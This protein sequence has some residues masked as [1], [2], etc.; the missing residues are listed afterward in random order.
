MKLLHFILFIV[1]LSLAVSAQSDLKKLVETENA[2]AK[3]AAEKGTRTAFLANM[4]D[5]AVVF[6]P[7]KTLARPHWTARGESNALLSWAPNFADISSDGSL[8]YTTG[9]WEWRAKG[10]DDAPSAFGEFVTIW[11]RQT[12]GRYKFV[13]DIGISHE[14]PA[15][16]SMDWATSAAAHGTIG[17]NVSA[18]AAIAHFFRHVETKGKTAAYRSAA[19]DEIR[20]FRENR[21][22]VVGKRSA[23]VQVGTEKGV[24]SFGSGEMISTSNLAYFVKGYTLKNADG[25]LEE[26]NVVQLWKYNAGRWNLVLDILEPMPKK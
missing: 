1:I 20:L 15:K 21:M 4:A 22:P 9:N 8:G 14:K 13:V 6:N 5:D 3:L 23:I 2:F 7:E 18:E 24:M 25:S 11:K 16:Y 26:G 19:A 12:D 17:G 10:R